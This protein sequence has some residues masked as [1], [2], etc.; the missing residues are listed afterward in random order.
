MNYNEFA[1]RKERNDEAALYDYIH[2]TYYIFPII[3]FAKTSDEVKCMI[4]VSR[5]TSSIIL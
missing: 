1:Y 2:D 3:P 5:I 4:D